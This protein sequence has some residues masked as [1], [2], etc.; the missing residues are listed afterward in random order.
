VKKPIVQ[1]VHGELYFI[2]NTMI[3]M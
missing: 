1:M 2:D 3:C